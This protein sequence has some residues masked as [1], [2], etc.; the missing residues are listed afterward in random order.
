MSHVNDWENP[1]LTNRNRMP[2]RAYAFSY[3][4][5]SSARSLDPARSPWVMS[6]D[7]TWKFDYSPSPAEAPQGFEVPGFDDSAWDTLPVPSCWQMHGY[8]YPHYTNVMYPFPVDPPRVPTDN[9]TGSYRREFVLPA[10]WTGARIMLRFEGVDSAFHVYVNGQEAGFS[11]GSRIPAEFDITELVHP[12]RNVL[13]VRVVQWSDGSYC[14]DQDMWWLSGIFRSVRLIAQPPVH[15]YDVAIRTTFDGAYRD[16]TL[17]TRVQVRNTAAAAA[18]KLRVKC[19]LLDSDSGSVASE[20]C[21][22][23]IGAAGQAV[24]EFSMPVS[25]P[26]QWTA[27]TPNL[28]TLLVSLEGTDTPLTVPVRLGFRQVE[29]R[30]ATLFVNGVPIKIKGVN[31]HEHHPDLGRSVPLDTMIQDILLMKRH[32]INAVRTSHYCDDPRWYDLCDYYGIYL[33]DECDLETHGFHFQHEWKGNPANDPEWEAAC[34]DRMER[35]VERDKNHP[36]VIIWSLGNESNFGCNHHSMARRAREIDPTRPLHYEGDHRAEASDMFS[37]M[38]THVDLVRKMGEG[39]EPVERWGGF[40]MEPE[41]Y[42]KKPFILCEY[43]HAMGNGPGGLLEYWDTIYR[44]PRLAGGCIWE[45]VDHGIR[46]HTPDGREYFA[47]GGDF[48][49]QPNDGNFVCDGLIFPDRIPSPG[50]IEYKK[51]IEPVK[52]EAVDAAGGRFRIT[53][54]Q[55]FRTLAYLNLAWAIE[56]DGAVVQSGTAPIPEVAPHGSADLQIAFA[57]PQACPGSEC[58][59]NLSFTLAAD[60]TWA[61]RGH[62]IAWAQFAMGDAGNA[63]TGNT[64]TGTPLPITAKV[65]DTVFAGKGEP[66]PAFP[67]GPLSVADNGT[68]IRVSGDDFEIEFSRVY[69]VIASWRAAGSDLLAGT[70]CRRAP[71]PASN[72]SIGLLGAIPGDPVPAL[73]GLPGPRLNFWRAVTDNDHSWDNAK[74]WRDARLDHLQHRTESVEVRTLDGGTVEIRAVT[75]IAPPVLD[76]GFLCDITYRIDRTGEVAIEVHGVPQGD[77]PP[78]LPRIGLQLALPST[79]GHVT[80][81]GP[82]PG[83][84]YP[85]TCQAQRVGLWRATVDELYTPYIRPQ[86][87][88]NRMDTRWVRLADAAGA[89]ILVT[90][91]PTINFGAHRFT[92]MD[93]ERARHTYELVPR[94]FITLSLDHRHNGIGT[95]SC[96][97]GPWEHYLLRPAEFRFSLTLKGVR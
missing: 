67:A 84:S 62:E 83:E 49:D 38:Y 24:T 4:D 53:N 22:I 77:M 43:A 64:G 92:T 3:P 36:S 54:R 80:W 21:E 66:V 72:H 25:A 81:F 94:D 79:F 26:R 47:Y 34:V 41:L 27:E 17:W 82:G 78:T 46:R 57:K 50:L 19:E 95:A 9:P 11:K 37:Q 15:I 93:L 18:A 70:S 35:M 29:I 76:R 30:E 33:I 58:F 40:V 60:E 28:Y 32:N 51:V 16:A 85:D 73:S 56:A 1:R 23:S 6:L 10:E 69:A 44:F 31:R 63:E 65:P 68:M 52:V 91:D 86:E 2:A 13:A 75:R 14:E 97:P 48:G 8:G 5:A 88:G 45:W 12:G 74:P 96:G 59:I 90:G 7:G 87:N 20:S 55:D 89:G 42:A 61:L 39:K 71:A